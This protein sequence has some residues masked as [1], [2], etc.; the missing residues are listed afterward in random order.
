MPPPYT[1][2]YNPVATNRARFTGDPLPSPWDDVPSGQGNT[3]L[4][5][6]VPAGYAA[7]SRMDIEQ[8]GLERDKMQTQLAD[9]YLRRREAQF[10]NRLLPVVNEADIAAAN[11][12]KT[13]AELEQQNAPLNYEA[14]REVTRL[15]GQ[16]A[17]AQQQIL[18]EK[19]A[20][21][22]LQTKDQLMNWSPT[23]AYQARLGH[24]TKDPKHLLAYEDVL[25]S[26]DRK[27]PL[28]Q[29]QQRAY[30]TTAALIQ[31]QPAVDAIESQLMDKPNYA[32][33]RS[34]L[35]QD[36][37][38]PDGRY[39]G[40]RVNP[41][42]D[43]GEVNRLLR[44]HENWKQ[45]RSMSEDERRNR[46]STMRYLEQEDDNTASRIRALE[47][48]G[49]E[50]LP[51]DPKMAQIQDELK[52]LNQRKADIKRKKDEASGL[53]EEHNKPVVAADLKRVGIPSQSEP[54]PAAIAPSEQPP[55]AAADLKKVQSPEKPAYD[56]KF[57]WFGQFSKQR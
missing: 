29:R 30:S 48:Q 56:S 52:A 12:R 53:V 38:T 24:L 36:E 51:S 14:D 22:S 4:G 17:I 28:P 2:R 57:G 13:T 11:L 47:N 9:N 1:S 20:L 39:L 6:Y 10:R 46:D 42:A 31:D 18:P 35:I 41:K 27:I 8:M 40:S 16:Q 44:A 19:A 25:N 33:L 49:A 23:D 37:M 50:L 7:S 55:A 5:A 45:K 34:K 3:M 32:E 15:R 54:T 26:Q 21:E 43:R